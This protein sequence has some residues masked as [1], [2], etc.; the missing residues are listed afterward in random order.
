M[1][2]GA[3]DVGFAKWLFETYNFVELDPALIVLNEDKEIRAAANQERSKVAVYTPYSFDVE[4]DLDLTGYRCVRIDLSS[5]QIMTPQV[6]SGARSRIA[7]HS[8]NGD[9]LFVAI[10]E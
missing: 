7:M 8:F 6:E 1:L 9:S 4:L 10:R 5:R 2:D 3:W